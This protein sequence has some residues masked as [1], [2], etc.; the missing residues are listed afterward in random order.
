[1]E[2]LYY[3][4]KDTKDGVSD[5]KSKKK[6][7]K[8]SMSFSSQLLLN[9]RS[10]RAAS[11][12][13]GQRDSSEKGAEDDESFSSG[14]PQNPDAFSSKRERMQSKS[15]LT[16]SDNDEEFYDAFD[17]EYQEFMDMLKLDQKKEELASPPP[18]LMV[19]KVIIEA[20]VKKLRL[21]IVE[22]Q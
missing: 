13:G 6:S 4:S 10:S 17:V 2:E 18:K 3:D 12:V 22:Q 16:N 15:G 20:W 19:H 1:M 5:K 8:K 11:S 14:N 21:E 9:H 7:F